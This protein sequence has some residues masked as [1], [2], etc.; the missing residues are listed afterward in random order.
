M[1]VAAASCPLFAQPLGDRWTSLARPVQ[2]TARF[3]GFGYSRGYHKGNPGPDSS[4][5]NPHTLKN[6]QRVAVGN[7]HLFPE[8]RSRQDLENAPPAWRPDQS[9]KLPPFPSLDS[10]P[11]SHHS[12]SILDREAAELW[13]GY[14][15]NGHASGAVPR[16][17]QPPTDLSRQ[18]GPRVKSIHQF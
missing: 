8:R 5:Y 13:S 6:S 7:E 15:S 11:L 1:V 16:L 10:P 4:Y 2:G 3:M 18:G 12:P 17:A 14:G 9:Q